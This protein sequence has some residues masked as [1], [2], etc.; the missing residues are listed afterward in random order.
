VAAGLAL[1]FAVG[2]NSGLSRL[3]RSFPSRPGFAFNAFELLHLDLAGEVEV[4]DRRLPPLLLDFAEVG[5]DRRLAHADYCRD[6]H[7]G[8]ALE[9]Q[10]SHLLAAL[11]N[12]NRATSTNRHYQFSK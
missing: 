4:T 11:V 10:I 3:L 7:L 6:L 9:I 2:G 5:R 1:V 12:S 8:L